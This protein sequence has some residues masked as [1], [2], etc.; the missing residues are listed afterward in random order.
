MST[1]TITVRGLRD[2]QRT[3][4][5][6]VLVRKIKALGAKVTVAATGRVTV[7]DKNGDRRIYVLALDHTVDGSPL[8]QALAD[9]EAT[10]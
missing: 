10:T 5:T 1:K 2:G 9:L 6:G 8:H 4:G 3:A 7:V